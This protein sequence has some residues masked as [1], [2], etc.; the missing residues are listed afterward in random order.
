MKNKLIYLVLCLSPLWWFLFVAFIKWNID[1]STWDSV[2][3]GLCL[4]LGLFT[5]VFGIGIKKSYDNECGY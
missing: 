2:D 5:S 1:I 3:R 4:S